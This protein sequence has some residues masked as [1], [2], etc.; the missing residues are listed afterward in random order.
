MRWFRGLAI[1][2]IVALLGFSCSESPNPISP[3][4]GELTGLAAFGIPPGATFESATFNVYI[5]SASGRETFVHRISAPWEE[6]VVTWNNFG[7]SFDPAVEGSFLADATGWHSADVSGLVANWLSGTYEPYGLL[8]DQGTANFPFSIFTSKEG[9]ANHPYLDVCYTLG[10]VLVCEQV[11]TNA[12][13]Y[14]WQFSPDLNRGASEILYTGWTTD[15]NYEK[16]ALFGFELEPTVLLAEIGDYV[17]FDNNING[18]QDDGEVGVPDVTVHLLDCAG[19]VLDEMLTDADGYYLFTD[20]MPGDYLIHFVAPEGYDFTL[21]DQGV[22]DAIDS[23]ADPTTGLAWCTDLDGGESDLTWDAGIYLVPQDGCTLTIGFWKTHAGFGP[24]RD[25][26]TQYLPIW[27]GTAGGS[28]SINVTDAQ[29]AVDVLGMSVYGDPS[30]GITKLYAQLLGAKLN[31]ANGADYSD[32]SAIIA[33]ADAYLADH[34]WTEWTSLHKNA[35]K[36]ILRW[37][38]DFDDYNNGEIGPGHCD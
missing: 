22:D 16:Q 14:I 29:T 7:G 32:V 5:Q 15:S 24:Q 3:D 8:L 11:I 12:D 10:G 38:N 30:N 1:L 31:I 2:A 20:L 27:L 4:T 37:M 26:V 25:F 9:L 21:Q 33:N 28:E 35:Q 6:M 13:S 18:I 36:M 17:W 34:S 23:D 19:N